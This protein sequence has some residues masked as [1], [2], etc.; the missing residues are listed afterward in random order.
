MST[1]MKRFLGITIKFRKMFWSPHHFCWNGWKIVF[2]LILFIKT[3]KTTC[4]SF[5]NL[6][7]CEDFRWLYHVSN[8]FLKKK[9]ELL[10]FGYFP[11]FVSSSILTASW[12]SIFASAKPSRTILVIDRSKPRFESHTGGKIRKTYKTNGNFNVFC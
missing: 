9:L 11:F 10:K 8:R 1:I 7:K 5:R 12:Q 2:L 3:E 4:K 6:L